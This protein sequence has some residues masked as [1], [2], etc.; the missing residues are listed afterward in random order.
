MQRLSKSGLK[1]DFVRPAILPDWWAKE[2]ENDPDLLADVELRVARFLEV[3]LSTVQ[4]PEASLGPPA[5]PGAQL[6]RVGEMPPER[7]APAIHS[8]L[9]IA[10]AVVR[11]LRNPDESV[12]ALPADG[13]AWR[14]HLVDSG[15]V[16]LESLLGDL[17][18][19]GIP[20]IPIERL[21]TPGFQGLAGIVEGRPVV[22][23]GHRHRE[24]GRVAFIVAHEAGHISAG[25]C[26]Q[27]RPVIDELDEIADD[28][29]LE[30]LADVFATQ[31]MVGSSSFPE[32]EG[33][34][35]RTLAKAAIDNER[36]TGADASVLIFSWARAQGD[37]G[38]ASQAVNAL[39]RAHGAR[40]T[41][42]TYFERFVE[43][44]AAP[45][46]DRALLQCVYGDV[47]PE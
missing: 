42:R 27:D 11:N 12:A 38:T 30:R 9:K 37:Y 15:A 18:E 35:F 39:Y 41:L 45:E 2:C 31:T 32:I 20:V 26:D 19:R 29:N 3:P 17:W 25:D 21:P 7:L 10:G 23:L 1:N 14:Q 8:A 34:N 46:S 5:Y 40:Q 44:D 24:P 47:N 33:S 36:E 4:D 13:L 16:T 28:T 43:I 6:R 22:V